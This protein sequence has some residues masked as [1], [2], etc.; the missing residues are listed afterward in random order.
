MDLPIYVQTHSYARTKMKDAENNLPCNICT[1][2]SREKEVLSRDN[3]F[4]SYMRKH[5]IDNQARILSK[6]IGGYQQQRKSLG[7]ETSSSFKQI[8]SNDARKNNRKCK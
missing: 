3:G 8:V 6:L 5:A 7:Q 2:E 1:I 4:D